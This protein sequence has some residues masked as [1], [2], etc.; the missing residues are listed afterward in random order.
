MRLNGQ[1]LEQAIVTFIPEEFMDPTIKGGSGTTDM[2]GTA[3]VAAEASSTPG[4]AY[5]LYRITVSKKTVTGTETI[6]LRYNTA[7][8]LGRELSPDPRGGTSIELSLTSP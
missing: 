1:P 7:T 6:P 8:T 5:G 3:S 4:L 2:N